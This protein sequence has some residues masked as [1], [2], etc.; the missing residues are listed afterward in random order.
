M[1][2]GAG[3]STHSKN[4][5]EM[6]GQMESSLGLGIDGGC[7]L[8]NRNRTSNTWTNSSRGMISDQD[9]VEE[10]GAYIEEYNQLA[11]KVSLYMM[12]QLSTL[13]ILLA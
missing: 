8:R 2:D 10:R 13:T 9:D 7:D 5:S 4:T 1:Y 12:S 3:C 11:K 6:N